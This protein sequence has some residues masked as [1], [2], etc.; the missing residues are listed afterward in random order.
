MKLTKHKSENNSRLKDMT[1][2]PHRATFCGEVVMNT[3]V[4]NTW[5]GVGCEDCWN[6]RRYRLKMRLYKVKRSKDE[7]NRD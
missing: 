3:E 5:K 2:P 7:H 6:E 4:T 1:P